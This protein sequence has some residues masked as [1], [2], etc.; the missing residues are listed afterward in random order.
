VPRLTRLVAANARTENGD[1]VLTISVEDPAGVP[2]GPIQVQIA[3]HDDVDV[4]W[5]AGFDCLPQ[6]GSW[7]GAISLEQSTERRLLQ[8]VKAIDSSGSAIE[9]D[10]IRLFLEPEQVGEWITGAQAEEERIRLDS[11]R[12][13]RYDVPLLALGTSSSEPKFAVIMISDKVL[14]S[15]NLRVPGVRVLPLT[16]VSLGMDLAHEL[17][18]L[19]PLFGIS[20]TIDPLQWLGHNRARLPAVAIHLPQIVATDEQAA[21]DLA[22]RPVH[23]LLDLVSLRRGATPRLLGGCI[24][25]YMKDGSI[26][27]SGAWAEGS[28]YTGNLLTG[29][30]TGED[31]TGLLMHWNAMNG[32]ARLRLWL[33][34]YA[35]AIADGRWDYRFFRCFNLLEGIGAEI[36]PRQ[37][38]VLDDQGNRR[39]KPSG[40]RYTTRDARGKILEL[41]RLASRRLSQSVGQSLWD[42]VGTWTKI[43]NRVAHAGGWALA[44]GEVPNQERVDLEAGI[45]ARDSSRSLHGGLEFMSREI[46][47]AA[48]TTLFAALRGL[49]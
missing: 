8:L 38:E 41:I 26:Q 2:A 24:G 22:R 6:V 46:Q 36:F 17:N 47:E 13:A 44:E 32:D 5:V 16:D 15:R 33:S 31:Q 20:G 25:R 3:Q 40:S 12:S 42:D 39:L 48:R 14:F 35:D 4:Y 11:A 23:Q 18:S 28:G 7:G 45:A 9:I 37:T 30:V 34:L 49:L 21:T 43:H 1:F 29:P 10:Q 19:L 27:L